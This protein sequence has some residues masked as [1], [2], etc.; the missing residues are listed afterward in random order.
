MQ[1]DTGFQSYKDFRRWCTHC[2]QEV[3]LS[4]LV[5]GADT[6][7]VECKRK[8]RIGQ[9]CFQ[10]NLALQRF[11]REPKT[12]RLAAALE[13]EQRAK[14]QCAIAHPDEHQGAGKQDETTSEVNFGKDN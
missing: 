3:P 10:K 11:L 13:I 12:R 1:N 9:R 4:R 2:K 7:S 14:A 5:R 8:D 6:C